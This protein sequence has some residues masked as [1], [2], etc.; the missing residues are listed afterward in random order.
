[1][2]NFINKNL[3]MIVFSTI[4]IAFFLYI[5]FSAV[6]LPS[7]SKFELGR[8]TIAWSDKNNFNN[9]NQF[10]FLTIPIL[11]LALIFVLRKRLKNVN[12]NLKDLAMISLG[13]FALFWELIY[14]IYGIKVNV[15]KGMELREAMFEQFKGGFDLCKMNTY[16]VGTFL[17]LRKPNMVKWVGAT[18]LFGGYSTLIDHYRDHAQIHSLITHAI[19]L[20]T[21]PSVALAMSGENYKVRNLIHAHLFNYVLVAVMYY[22]NTLWDGVAGELTKERME[23]NMLVGFAPWPTNMF[24]WIFAVMMVEWLF[25]TIHRIIINFTYEKQRGV[26]FITSFKLEFDQDKKEWYGFKLWGE[27]SCFNRH[28]KPIFLFQHAEIKNDKKEY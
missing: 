11:S 17:V 6:I 3:L 2:K 22:T 9:I 16:I 18:A 7:S 26:S 1:M 19:I 10:I 8:F 4:L 28:I 23:D 24:L 12:E 13:L 21:F 20:S 5:G 15:E 25:F 14:D 27:N